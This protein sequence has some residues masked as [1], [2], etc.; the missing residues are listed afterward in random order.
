MGRIRTIKP[1][2]HAHEELSALPAETHL[3]AAALTNYADDEGFFNANPGLVKAG[4]HPLRTDKTS[5]ETQMKQLAAMGFIEVRKSQDG[6]LIGRIVNFTTHQKI[7]HASDS[8]LKD[9]FES[10]GETPEGYVK[11]KEPLRPDQGTG[12]REKEQGKEREALVERVFAFYCEHVGKDL[13]RYTLTAERKAKA[14]SRIVERLKVHGDNLEPVKAELALVI[15]NLMASDYHRENGYLDWTEQIFRSEEEF[16]KRLNWQKPTGGSDGKG[17]SG[18]TVDAG[19]DFL[20]EEW[21]RLGLNKSGDPS[22]SS[23]TLEGGPAGVRG[24]PYALPAA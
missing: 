20:Q 4:T 21:N 2:F 15:R 12:N 23:K 5:T 1:E 10:S 8:K 9:R 13:K 11:P 17:R 6:K 3:L 7:S 22:P 16:Q 18:Q 24:G 14:L 19:R